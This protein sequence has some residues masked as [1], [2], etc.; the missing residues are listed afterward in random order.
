VSQVKNEPVLKFVQK[1]QPNF[2]QTRGGSGWLAGSN[3]FW[4]L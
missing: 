4:Q 3:P 2:A 1:F